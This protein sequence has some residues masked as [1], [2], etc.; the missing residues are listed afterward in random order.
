L[1]IAAFDI[2]SK[3]TGY[4]ITDPTGSM[5]VRSGVI[6]AS[7]DELPQKIKEM[8]QSYNIEK[9]V[10]GLPVT[11]KGS[12]SIQTERVRHLINNLKETIGIQVFEFD[13][14]LTTVEA[15]KIWRELGRSSQKK[16]KLNEIAAWLI[17]ESFLKRGEHINDR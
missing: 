13:E 6:E 16:K 9:V 2:G 1:R 17:L 7:I 12:Y 5:P 4:A 10:V 3:Y 15:Q 14:R 8:V 11:L